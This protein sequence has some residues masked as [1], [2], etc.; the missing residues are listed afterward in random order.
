MGCIV[1]TRYN[2]IGDN[3]IDYNIAEAADPLQVCAGYRLLALSC[4]T[5]HEK[6]LYDDKIEAA[7][8]VDAFNLVNLP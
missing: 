6:F 3:C 7:L 1:H 5:C 4:N 8:Q 2:D